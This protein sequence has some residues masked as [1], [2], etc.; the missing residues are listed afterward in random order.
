M[1]CTSKSCCIHENNKIESCSAWQYLKLIRRR[2]KDTCMHTH[3]HTKSLRSRS[4]TN[5][6]KFSINCFIWCI[7][8]LWTHLTVWPNWISFPCISKRGIY[9][10][11]TI[12][13][14]FFFWLFFCAFLFGTWHSCYKLIHIWFWLYQL[15]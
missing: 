11:G 14:L 7:C 13:S 6:R 15:I 5:W 12:Y 4:V 1:S 10:I 9:T 3:R 8:I 2:S